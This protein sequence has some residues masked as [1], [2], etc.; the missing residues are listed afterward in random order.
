M[1]FNRTFVELKFDDADNIRMWNQA[2]NRT[3][4]ELKLQINI[5]EGVSVHFF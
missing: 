1:T 3:F 5:K 4:V 2:F